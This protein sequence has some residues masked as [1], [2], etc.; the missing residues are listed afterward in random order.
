MIKHY[1]W[2]R[3]SKVIRQDNYTS[4]EI[5]PE[6]ARENHLNRCLSK[7]FEISGD[8]SQS[9]RRGLRARSSA[10]NFKQVKTNISARA[11]NK[12]WPL[13][14]YFLC[15]SVRAARIRPRQN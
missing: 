15:V 6:M 8:N 2:E 11:R 5:R 13:S 12:L 10:N 7:R 1:F 3:S 9:E 4:I 14:R